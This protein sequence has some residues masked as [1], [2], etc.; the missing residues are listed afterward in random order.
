MI[1]Q[2]GDLI[3][4]TYE[5]QFFIGQG[6]FGEVYRVKHKFFN[7]LQV[8]K[9]F[10][11]ECIENANPKEIMNEG[12]ILTH[13]SHPNVVKV[14]DIRT[15]NKKEN[16]YYF[17]TMSFVSGESLAQ[18]MKRKIQLDVPVATSILIDVLRG[19]TAAHN[20]D[21][22][23][24]H[25]DISPDNILL[26]YDNYKPVGVLGDFGIA[27]LLSQVNEIPG[28]NGKFFYFAPECFMNIYL[29]TSDVFAAA[30]V[31]YK[32]L[33]GGHPWEY[34]MKSYNLNENEDISRMINSGR[35]GN[36]IK[37]SIYNSDID[38]KLENVIM[39]ALEK[40]IENRYRTAGS[41]LKA[42]ESTVEMDDISHSYWLKQDLVSVN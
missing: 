30:I 10:K 21:P 4:D 8:M 28:A 3:N 26:S 35:K 1:L 27:T 13:L 37:P 41:F 20:N 29:P 25:R 17:I 33:T 22:T 34:D 15:F 36:A 7:K 32:I 38:Q 16:T 40:N 31:L 24:I 6:A 23:I 18:L 2:N 14:F 9:V 12:E 39:K 42:L 11:S 19:L 5:I